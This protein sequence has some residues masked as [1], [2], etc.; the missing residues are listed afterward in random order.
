MINV[1]D[2]SNSV[3][4]VAL[5]QQSAILMALREINNKTDG[6]H[7]DILPVTRL[8]TMFSYSLPT[9]LDSVAKATNMMDTGFGG[10]G[11]RAVI[12][13]NG[14]AATEGMFEFFSAH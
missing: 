3:G 11:V 7:D 4:N 12:G 9:F 6:I 1:A 13:A 5:Q 2:S 8:N 10:L 14:F